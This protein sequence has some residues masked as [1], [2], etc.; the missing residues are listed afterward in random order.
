MATLLAV[1]REFL[2]KLGIVLSGGEWFS[3]RATAK[4]GTTNERRV[5]YLTS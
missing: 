3:I 2:M 1:P 5:I 4:S